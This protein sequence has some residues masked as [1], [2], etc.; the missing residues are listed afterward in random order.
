MIDLLVDAFLMRYNYYMTVLLML[1]GIYAMI[2][3]TN[4]IK[5]FIGLN[6]FQTAIFLFYISIGDITGGTAPIIIPD[7]AAVYVNPLPHVLMLTG[8]VVAVSNTAV[9]LALV[10]RI[11]DKY[12]SIDEAEIREGEV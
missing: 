8:I 12:G 11:F 2:A 1:V 4:M 6:I 10:I 3:K 7:P 9:A 5:K